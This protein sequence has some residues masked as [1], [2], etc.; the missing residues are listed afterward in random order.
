MIYEVTG[1]GTHSYDDATAER[2]KAYY[3]Y[4]TAFDNGTA[5]GPDVYAPAGGEVLESGQYTNMTTAPAYLTRPP[6]ETLEDIRVVPNPYN[7]SATDLNYPGEANKIMFLDLPLECTIYIYN[8]TLDLIKT[9]EHYGSGDEPWGLTP[10]E[11][12][13]TETGQ[14]VVSGLYIAVI[15]TPEGESAIR[16]IVI[17]R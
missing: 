2:G 9:I 5:N 6:G 4:V 16:K 10:E 12:M 8:E 7:F 17:V 15:E 1:S 14:L 13:A 3:Y 11:H